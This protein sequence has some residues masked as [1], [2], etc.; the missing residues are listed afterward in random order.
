MDRQTD[1]DHL[2]ALLAGLREAIDEAENTARPADAQ[3]CLTNL[4]WHLRTLY[5]RASGTGSL[6]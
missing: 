3:M 2:T 6:A 1:F 4:L 5:R